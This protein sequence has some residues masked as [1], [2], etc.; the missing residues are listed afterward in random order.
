MLEFFWF[1]VKMFTK[2]TLAKNRRIFLSNNTKKYKKAPETEKL[3]DFENGYAPTIPNRGFA[4]KWQDQKP[5]TYNLN[6]LLPYLYF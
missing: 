5:K 1:Q 3:Q 6:S 4:S 2:I